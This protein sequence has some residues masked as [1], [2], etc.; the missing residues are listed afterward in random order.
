MMKIAYFSANKAF[1]TVYSRDKLSPCHFFLNMDRSWSLTIGIT[2]K[3]TQ[4]V[5]PMYDAD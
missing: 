3:I 1:V 4:L 2:I 5:Q